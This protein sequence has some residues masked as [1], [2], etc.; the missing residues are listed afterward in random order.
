M[1]TLTITLDDEAFEMLQASAAQSGVSAEDMAAACV[2]PMVRN[3]QHAVWDV[4]FTAGPLHCGFERGDVVQAAGNGATG[5]VVDANDVRVRVSVQRGAQEGFV[6]GDTIAGPKA[7]VIVTRA[8][9]IDALK[10]F[11][12]QIHRG[13]HGRFNQAA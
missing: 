10:V 8:E 12:S 13:D 9:R 2:E 4:E 1:K 3:D 7:R 5:L 11:E 6:I